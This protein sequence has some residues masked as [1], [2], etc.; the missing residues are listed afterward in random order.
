MD[1]VLNR[2]SYTGDDVYDCLEKDYKTRE[3]EEIEFVLFDHELNRLKKISILPRGYAMPRFPVTRVLVVDGR[4]VGYINVNDL[5]VT[6]GF[7]TGVSDSAYSTL[8]RIFNYGPHKGVSDM[9]LD[10]RYAESGAIEFASQL[11]YMITGEEPSKGKQFGSYDHNSGHLVLSHYNRVV[12]FIDACR[13]LYPCNKWGLAGTLANL[14]FYQVLTDNV[15]EYSKKLEPVFSLGRV[16]IL[17]SEETC[18]I[19]EVLINGFLGIDFDVILIGTGTCGKPYH[20][21]Y[22]GSCGIKYFVPEFRFLN[23]KKFGDYIDGFRPENSPFEKGIPVKGC[24]VEE[25]LTKQLGSE[26]E[27]LLAAALQYREDGTCPTLPENPVQSASS[28]YFPTV[29]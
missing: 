23:N 14:F 6:G 2:E 7:A 10:L 11:A 9:I 18:G 8:K 5:Y 25:D 15:E 13:K 29:W 12:P 20:G 1:S 27:N 16:F 19:S 21:R 17:T 24:Y 3:K 4:K 26:D 22:Y 28:E